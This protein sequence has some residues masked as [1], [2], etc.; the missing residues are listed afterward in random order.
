MASFACLAAGAEGKRIGERHV[1]PRNARV[2]A[3]AAG[4]EGEALHDESHPFAS[5]VWTDCFVNRGH[6]ESLEDVN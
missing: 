2:D 3:V 5:I 1:F 6:E 4:A